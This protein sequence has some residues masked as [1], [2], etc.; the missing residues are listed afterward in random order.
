M[1]T[2]VMGDIHGAY[3][4]FVQCLERSGF[5]P[6]TDQ[7]IQLGDIVDGYPQ[8]YEVMEHLLSIPD[9]ILIKGNHDDWLERYMATGIHPSSWSHG[10]EATMISYLQHAGKPNQIIRTFSGFKNNM[11]PTDIPQTHKKLLA[12]QHLYYKDAA[13]RLFVHGGFNRKLRLT[14]QHPTDF[15]W[16]RN[17]LSTALEIKSALGEDTPP[18][19]FY[20]QSDI[21]AV[22]IGHTPTTHL[23]RRLATDTPVQ[24]LNILDL[25]TGAGHHGRLT[26]LELTADPGGSEL[27][28]YPYWQSDPVGTL[29]DRSYR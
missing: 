16:D 21:S 6:Q 9:K 28:R 8:V 7:L 20:E 17:L 29:Y 27:S 25:D 18:E 5:N 24:A 4:A 14:D 1:R 2:F 13:G 22:F 3:K 15:F 12:S 19:D 11:T 26:V 10:G 23:G